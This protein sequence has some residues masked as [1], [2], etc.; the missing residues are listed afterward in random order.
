MAM[1]RRAAR[2]VWTC[3]WCRGFIHE[4]LQAGVKRWVHDETP[5]TDHE[6]LPY[7]VSAAGQQWISSS[8]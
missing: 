3:A 7:M 1:K 5:A 4:V 6:V 2:A 8:R